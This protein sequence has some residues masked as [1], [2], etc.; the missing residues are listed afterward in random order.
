MKIELLEDVDLVLLKGL[1]LLEADAFGSG[2][3]NEWHLVPL[4]RHGR[5]FVAREQQQALGLIQYLR[6]WNNPYK[7]YL[8]GVSVAKEMRGKGLGTLLIRTSLQFM[9]KEDIEEVEL[10]VDP[11]NVGAI[12]IYSEKFGFEVKCTRADEYGAGENRLVMILSLHNLI[13]I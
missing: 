7:A 2:G 11:E 10:T 5:V 4:I 9:K 1:V 6:D 12:K 13:S 3:L 8:M